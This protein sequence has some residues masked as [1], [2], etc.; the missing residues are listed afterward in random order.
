MVKGTCVSGREPEL[1]YFYNHYSQKCELFEFSGCLG[2][3]NNFRTREECAARC[4]FSLPQSL[5]H[6]HFGSPLFRRGLENTPDGACALPAEKGPCSMYWTRYHWDKE[7][8]D[9]REFTYSGCAGNE[10]NFESKEACRKYCKVGQ[11]YDREEHAR[12]PKLCKLQATTG[13]CASG[14][15]PVLRYFYNQYKKKCELFIY[16]GCGGNENN[17]ETK[18][19]CE[20]RCLCKL[21]PNA[22]AVTCPQP[23]FCSVSTTRYYWDKDLGDCKAFL[24][25]GCAGNGNNFPTK[26]SCQ[27]YCKGKAFLDAEVNLTCTEEVDA[28]NCDS[29]EKGTPVF[30]FFYDRNKSE[31]EIF[32][33]SGCNGNENKFDT[34]EEC[35][36]WC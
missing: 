36:E 24:Y 1:R 19:A 29:D 3:E 5:S 14:Q 31:C 23:G 34:E 16:S 26:E 17:F 6:R 11:P 2:N 12:L 20:N 10:N 21:L 27:T 28:G 25:T 13:Q 9:C 15:D 32:S 8:G 30:K 33:Y 7:L 22:S 4:I 35:L 18:E